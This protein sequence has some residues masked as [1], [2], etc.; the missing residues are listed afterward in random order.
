MNQS[1]NKT[2][3]KRVIG[4]DTVPRYRKQNTGS[5][6]HSRN[7]PTGAFGITLLP[8]YGSLQGMFLHGNLGNPAKLSLNPFNH[9]ALNIFA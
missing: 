2:R 7:L 1:Q 4:I 3:M 6:L 9:I 8:K 5:T